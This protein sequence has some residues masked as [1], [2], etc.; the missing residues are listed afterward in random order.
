MFVYYMVPWTCLPL[1]RRGWQDYIQRSDC[2]NQ[3][4]H[5]GSWV[6]RF[7]TWF[8]D[9][10]ISLSDLE[11]VIYESWIFCCALGWK[12]SDTAL[13]VGYN[14][15]SITHTLSHFARNFFLNPPV[16]RLGDWNLVLGS[17]DTFSDILIIGFISTCPPGVNRVNLYLIL[18]FQPISQSIS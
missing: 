10:K 16:L 12:P 17:L 3:H 18:L 9:F 15:P 8:S 11:A 5:L 2:L 13:Y 6:Y 4:S 7:G 1:S 14:V